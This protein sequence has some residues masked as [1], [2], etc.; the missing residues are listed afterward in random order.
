MKLKICL[1]EEM[2]TLL[3]PL[4]SRA[5]MSKKG[6][7]KDEDAESAVAR[8]DYGFSRLAVKEKTQIMLAIRSKRIDDFTR[9]YLADHPG[10]VVLYLGCG[11]DS[12]AKRLGFPAKLWY[13]I[14]FPE[15]ISIK[16]QLHQETK[17]YRYIASSVT[18][19]T[20]MDKAEFSNGAVLVIA[21]GS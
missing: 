13:D 10:G 21:E 20:W 15:I 4:Y 2:E 7:F 16:Q 6:L 8:I 11:L 3:I 9:Q 1:Q 18:D 17:S 12:R 19:W 14:D 5:V